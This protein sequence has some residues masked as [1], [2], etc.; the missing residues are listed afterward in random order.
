MSN[1]RTCDSAK[2]NPLSTRYS[3][4]CSECGARGLAHS[5]AHQQSAATGL[6]HPDYF[7]ALCAEFGP[8]NWRAGHA[9]VKVWAARI[10]QAKAAGMTFKSQ[11]EREHHRGT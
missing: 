11:P 3:A 10:Q 5:L 4:H 7:A 8:D 1:C 9:R 6:I 2:L